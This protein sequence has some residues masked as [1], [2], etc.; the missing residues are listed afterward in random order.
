MKIYETLHLNFNQI[1][2]FF[3]SII[4]DTHT[5]ELSMKEIKVIRFTLKICQSVSVIKR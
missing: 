4:V 3:C 2:G 5:H 1:I